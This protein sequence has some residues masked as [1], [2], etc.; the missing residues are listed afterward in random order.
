MA[1]LLLYQRATQKARS[2]EK[3]LKKD[4]HIPQLS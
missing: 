1:L 4:G 3:K 2:E